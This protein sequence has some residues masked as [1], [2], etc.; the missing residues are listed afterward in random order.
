[1]NAAAPPRD[2]HV[3]EAGRAELLLLI[4]WSSENGVRVRVH[5]SGGE[6]PARAVDVIDVRKRLLELSLRPDGGDLVAAH[7][8]R[9]A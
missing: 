8:D 4:A 9:N 7:G 6:E 3:I 1:V 5:E 2:L